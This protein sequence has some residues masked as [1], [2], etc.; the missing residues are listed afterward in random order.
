MRQSLAARLTVPLTLSAGLI[1][2]LGLLVDYRLSRAG[3]IEQLEDSA[4]S[5]LANA[6]SLIDGMAEGVEN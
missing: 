6:R 1:I 3:I 5:S 2:A 4:R